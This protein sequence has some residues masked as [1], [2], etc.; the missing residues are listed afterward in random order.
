ML[1]A[2][3]QILAVDPQIEKLLALQEHDTHKL[4]IEQQ[5]QS[6]P[7]ERDKLKKRIEEEQASFAEKKKEHQQ[8]EIKRSEMRTERRSVEDKVVKYKTQQMQVKKNDEYQALNHEIESLTAKAA[9][10]EEQE[11]ELL[12]KI[13]EAA[14]ILKGL[15]KESAERVALFQKELET[16]SEKEATL[17]ASVDEVSAAV[18]NARTQVDAKYLAAYDSVKSRYKKPPFVVPIV[19]GKINGLKVSNDVYGKARKGEE[20]VHCDNTGRIAYVS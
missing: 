6:I 11:L 2:E 13:D 5:L 17:K 19:D 8:L 4:Q 18:E 12:F 9:E 3:P 14:E 15:E 1:M 7:R 20:P 16:L 10:I